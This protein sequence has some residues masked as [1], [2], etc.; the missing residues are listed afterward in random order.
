LLQLRLEPGDLFLEQL[1]LALR[2]P[3]LLVVADAGDAHPPI[4][5]LGLGGREP[6]LEVALACVERGRRGATRVGRGGLLAVC[7]VGRRHAAF[8]RRDGGGVGAECLIYFLEL[9]EQLDLRRQRCTT[10]LQR[11]AQCDSNTR[12]TGYEPAALTA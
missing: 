5:H 6:L 3:E 10:S 7:V 4:L 11:W 2:E 12:P 1:D 8:A 9:D